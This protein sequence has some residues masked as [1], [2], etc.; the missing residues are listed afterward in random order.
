MK[1]KYKE[2]YPHIF[3]PFTV[4]EHS[5]K[6]LTFKNRFLSAPMAAV[7]QTDGEGLL[8]DK[9]AEYYGRFARGGMASVCV[10][11]EIPHNGGHARSINIDDEEK[12]SFQDVHRLQRLVHAYDTRS[13]IE[14]YHA[15]CCMSPG[16]GR[17]PLA[18]CDM[19]WNGHFVCGMNDKDMEEVLNMYVQT[20]WYGKRAGFEGILLHFGHGW[21]MNNFLSP[22]T[23]KRT[24]EFGG[25]VENRCRYPLMI[26]KAIREAL[27]DMPIELRLNGSDVMEGGITIPD[28][29]EQALIFSD[30]VDMMHMTCGTRLDAMGRTLM[31]PTHFVSPGHNS[32]ASAAVKKAFKAAGI[33]I[34]VGVVGSIHSAQLAEDLIAQEK[35]DYVLVG[36]QVI[37]DYDWVNKVREGREEDIRPCLR[38]DMCLDSGRRP[39]LTKD[40]TYSADATYDIYCAINVFHH[41]GDIKW[42]IPYPDV[43]KKVAIVGGG[44]SGIKAALTA[45]ERGH[46][47]TLYEKDAKLGGQLFFSDHMWFKK[48]I[49]A[50]LAYMVTQLRKSN[51]KVLLNT[52]A[53]P[54]MLD[55][56]DYD[57]VIVAVG[58]EPIIPPIPGVD[59][60]HVKAAWDCFGHEES[61]GKDVVIIGGG[62]VGCEISIHLAEK[63]MNLTVVEMGE[64]LATNAQ[65]TERMDTLAHMEE[66][67]TQSF[68]NTT[69]VEILDDGVVIEDE[70]GN[71]QTLKADTVLVA[72]GM[73]SL[74]E[75][76]D[77]FKDVAF[78]VKYVG[79]CKSVGDI[80]TCVN[81]G[82]DAAATL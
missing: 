47:V 48:E 36:R 61:L 16:G 3:E 71:R 33:T 45:D 7:M 80:C 57:A 76:R 22:I 49:K 35:A 40:V 42:K 12:V 17:E 19:M 44:I 65:L 78:D 23:N 66:D 63:G 67:K 27:P 37:A 70:N 50:Y 69:C 53:T 29:V 4:G 39:A 8:L 25:S 20:A 26:I 81:S 54:E 18:P 55:L 75:E 30:Y 72:C 82:F 38:C 21:L 58:A 68:T 32:D 15:G 74:V 73:K 62:M 10:P 46:D 77:K 6:K 31:H 59:K 1:P 60:P 79:D 34:P 2:R 11:V 9:G 13:F 51:V 64:Y 52:E 56:E 28:A 43:K 24:D 41:Q 5:T 14:I